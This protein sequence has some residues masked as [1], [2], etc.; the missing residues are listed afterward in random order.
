MNNLLQLRERVINAIRAES[1]LWDEVVNTKDEVLDDLARLLLELP[2]RPNGDI[3][4]VGW[5]T[6]TNPTVTTPKHISKTG[7]DLIKRWEGW[8]AKAY[9]CPANKWTIGYGHTKTACRGMII[10]QQEGER[11]LRQDLQIYENAINSLVSVTLNQNQFDA[12]VSF[13]YNVGRGALSQST[14]LIR[15]NEGNYSEAAE[16]F[17]RWVYGGGRKL[18]GLVS[19]RAAER[20]LFLL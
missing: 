11:L 14:L 5:L 16:Q 4:Y 10:S 3:P 8:R 13:T 12:L 15:L 1:S 20:Q 9:K 19:R 18:P 6:A 17:L 2:A 7:I